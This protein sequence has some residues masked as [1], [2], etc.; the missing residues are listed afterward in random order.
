MDCNKPYFLW[1][2]QVTFYNL[3]LLQ[4]VPFSL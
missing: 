2:P 4:V 1:V 3:G